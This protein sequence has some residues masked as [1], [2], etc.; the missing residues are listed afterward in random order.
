MSKQCHCYFDC[1]IEPV[2]S[3]ELRLT[4][5]FKVR[6]K[7][8]LTELEKVGACGVLV[9]QVERPFRNNGRAYISGIAFKSEQCDKLRNWQGLFI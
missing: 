4:L 5:P 8:K 6:D 3:I 1:N 7:E 2:E 9:S